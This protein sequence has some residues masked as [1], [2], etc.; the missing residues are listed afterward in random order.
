M[1]AL[2][3]QVDTGVFN[4]LD[5]PSLA[6]G[7]D[8]TTKRATLLLALEEES[9]NVIAQ[10][11]KLFYDSKDFTFEEFNKVIEDREEMAE[12]RKK[13]NELELEDKADVGWFM[14]TKG[15]LIL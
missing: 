5:A 15:L 14:Y 3:K 6:K 7:K 10:R 8:E 2:I 13:W 11:V 12:P 1:K 9:E 4:H